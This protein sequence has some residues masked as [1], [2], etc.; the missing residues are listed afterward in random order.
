MN[1]LPFNDIIIMKKI[2]P[3]NIKIDK[4]SYRNIPIYYIGYITI[5]NLKYVNINSVNLLYLVFSKVDGKKY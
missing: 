2:D 1:L 4:K 5:K 3:N